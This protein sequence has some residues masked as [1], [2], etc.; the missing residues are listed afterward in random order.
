MFSKPSE[1]DGLTVG[2]ALGLGMFL[3]AVLG[4]LLL[5]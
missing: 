4:I 1:M 2:F 3:V 5:I